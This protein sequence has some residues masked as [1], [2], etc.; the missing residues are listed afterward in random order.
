MLV[1]LESGEIVGR[2]W[3]VECENGERVELAVIEEKVEC[4][5]R[6]EWS[7]RVGEMER[8]G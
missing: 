4:W 2:E 8:V 3:G 6:R 5:R 7:M 1:E